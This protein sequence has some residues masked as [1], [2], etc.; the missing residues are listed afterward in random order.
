VAF[1]ALDVLERE[2]PDLEDPLIGRDDVVIT[3][4]AAFFSAWPSGTSGSGSSTSCSGSPYA[5]T[6]IARIGQRSIMI[7][8]APGAAAAA[9]ASV[10]RASGN[11]SETSSA[12]RTRPLATASI[13]AGKSSALAERG[14]ATTSS[15]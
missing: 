5:V 13:D 1:A 4:H 10:A 11:R 7:L 9:T 2:P 14:C 8:R 12:T 15:L 3:P 6:A